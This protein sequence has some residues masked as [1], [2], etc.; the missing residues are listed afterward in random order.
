MNTSA[1]TQNDAEWEELRAAGLAVTAAKQR[2]DEARAE[3]AK[4]KERQRAARKAWVEC[5]GRA[6]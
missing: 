6:R 3:W 4:A 1:A 5:Q 2:V